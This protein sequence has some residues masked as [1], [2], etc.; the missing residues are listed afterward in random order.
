MLKNVR[1]RFATLSAFQLFVSEQNCGRPEL[2]TF[3]AMATDEEEC[4]F[5][6]VRAEYLRELAEADI[7][8]LA[9]ITRDERIK[10]EL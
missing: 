5:W 3:A 9:S 1:V 10:C 8:I 6:F 7:S 4:T 2:L